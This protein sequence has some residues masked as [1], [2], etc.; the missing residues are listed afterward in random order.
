MILQDYNA[1]AYEFAIR[2]PRVIELLEQPLTDETV[3]ELLKYGINA[4]SVYMDDGNEIVINSL[5]ELYLDYGYLAHI[6]HTPHNPY[7]EEDYLGDRILVHPSSKDFFYPIN[8]ESDEEAIYRIDAPSKKLISTQKLNKIERVF[9]HYDSVTFYDETVYSLDTSTKTK[10][11][12]NSDIK[13]VTKWLQPEMYLQL[14][15]QHIR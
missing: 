6:E 7:G 3:S 1:L 9:E 5:Q 12:I 11:T 15:P 10:A 13:L 14:I 8:K 4:T 2:N